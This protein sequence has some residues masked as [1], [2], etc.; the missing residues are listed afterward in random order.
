MNSLAARFAGAQSWRR[1]VLL[2]AL[3]A[4]ATLGM[5]PISFTPALLVAFVGFTWTLDGSNRAWRGAW[6]GWWFGFGFF[7]SGLYWVANALLTDVQ[8][9]AW[10]VPLAVLALPAV[11]ALFTALAGL[12]AYLLWYPGAWRVLSLAVAWTAAEWL[13]GHLF[14][15]FPWNLVGYTWTWSDAALQSASLFGIYGLSFATVFVL[16]APAA[17]VVAR[18][19]MPFDGKARTQG[20]T[21]EARTSS[22]S[23]GWRMPRDERRGGGVLVFSLA[24]VMLAG[25]FAYGMVRLGDATDAV[26]DG[27]T[28]RLV[29]ANVEQEFKWEPAQLR[30]NLERHLV[31]TRSP[32][33]EKVGAVVW[34]ETALPYALDG[35]REL[36]QALGALLPSGAVLITGVPRIETDADGRVIT[37]MWNSVAV[38]DSTGTVVGTYDKAHLVPFGEYVP[39]RPLLAALGLEKVVPGI[40]DYS[41]GSGPRTLVLPGLPDVSPLVCYEV[42]FPGAVTGGAR[43]AWLLNV[44]NDAWYGR[45]AGPYQHFAM[46]RV[47]AVEEGLP[48]VRA[49]NTGIS[50]VVDSYGRVRASLGLMEAGV[51]DSELPV[52]LPPTAYARLADWPLAAILAL[53]ALILA[54]GTRIAGSGERSDW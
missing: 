35:N 40:L 44:T 5:P 3:G 47:R 37:E 23:T 29:Q 38:L 28:L 50:G 48:L 36:R 25:D 19:R 24:L 18:P 49:A 41:A 21:G 2:F 27:V 46:A 54:V 43:P 34:P 6:D 45:S 32:G 15:G 33:L 8:Q 13:R 31:L 11:L 22:D 42:I 39:L 17:L 1:C 7:V 53:L 51:V 12:L 26:Q 16:A 20:G 30:A 4:I 10:L 14:T 52:P 9:F